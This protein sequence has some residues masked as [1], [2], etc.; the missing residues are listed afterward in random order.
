MRN[1]KPVVATAANAYLQRKALERTVGD[2]AVEA[3]RM[4]AAGCEDPAAQAQRVLD[5][6]I[7]LQ[8]LRAEFELASYFSN[9]R[10]S[11]DDTEMRQ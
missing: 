1:F 4:I 11:G 3:I 2:A 6:E 9:R 8:Q 5:L 10:N 7:S